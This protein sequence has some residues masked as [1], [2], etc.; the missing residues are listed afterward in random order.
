MLCGQAKERSLVHL[1]H[2]TQ[3]FLVISGWATK[4]KPGP[5]NIGGGFA[6]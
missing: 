3:T 1:K 5:G 2:P 6:K 4:G